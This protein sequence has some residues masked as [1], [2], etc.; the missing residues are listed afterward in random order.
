M[1]GIVG[2]MGHEEACALLMDALKRLEYRGYDSAGIAI[3][4]KGRIQVARKQ[5]KV[6]DLRKDVVND[7]AFHGKLGLAHTRWLPMACHRSEMHTPIRSAMSWW[8]ITVLSRIT[9]N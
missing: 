9:W 8:F 7:V 3:W 6:D 4:D 2:Y 5:G 1:C